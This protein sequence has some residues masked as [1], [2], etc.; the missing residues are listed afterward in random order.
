LTMANW[1]RFGQVY[2]NLLNLFPDTVL[3]DYATNGQTGDV[4]IG[5]VFDRITR[6]IVRA[7]PPAVVE[8]LYQVDA[9]EVVRYATAGQTTFS[10]GIVPMI[11]GTLH[12]WQYPSL[13]AMESPV[14]Y[15]YAI[16]FSFRRPV[17]G[18]N[19]IAAGS[20][21]YN[22]TS[23]L[24]TLAGPMVGGLSVGQRIFATY[25]VDVE[26]ATFAMPS[27]ADVVLYGAAA[28]LGSSLYTD[29]AAQWGRVTDYKNRFDGVIENLEA[30][31]W[32]P[33]E[34]RRLH[35]WVEVTPKN[36]EIKSV[37]IHRA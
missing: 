30:G 36:A 16:E 14:L 3:T 6:E 5:N 32:V 27:L 4:I 37:R 26:N 13:A 8:S 15:G 22:P 24:V 25:D 17:K 9:E 29:A 7:M 21:T 34:I 11:N 28:E 33:D 12:L 1:N 2:T 23:G 18:F 35:H 20:Y 31:T 10:L 19:E